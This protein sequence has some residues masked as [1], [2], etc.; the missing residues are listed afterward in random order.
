MRQVRSDVKRFVPFTFFLLACRPGIEQVYEKSF[1]LRAARE[2]AA[3]GDVTGARYYLKRAL[4]DAAAS[5]EAN[6]FLAQMSERHEASLDCVA[7]KRA[8]LAINQYPRVRHKNLFQLA[9][10]LE[11]AGEE[12]RAL[13]TYNLSENAGSTQ[14]QLYL[15]RGF[16]KE[17]LGDIPGAKLDFERAI[18]LNAGYFP[19][20]LGYAMFLL[21]SGETA[22]GRKIAKPFYAEIIA[23]AEK[24][25]GILKNDATGRTVSYGK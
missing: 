7:A 21:R 14:P 3:I 22:S 5:T 18:K 17:R 15:R 8:D 25:R 20:E 19:A 23:D 1:E 10:C 16:L 9:V 24:N 2:L 12:T 6:R 13:A 4:T 11:G